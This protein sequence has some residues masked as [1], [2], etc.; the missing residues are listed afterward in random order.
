MVRTAYR[1]RLSVPFHPA[2]S[3]RSCALCFILIN[4][5]V[6]NTQQIAN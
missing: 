6:Q 2:L 3:S 4:I 1:E 5:P